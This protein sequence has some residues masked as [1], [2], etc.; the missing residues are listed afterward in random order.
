MIFI[1]RAS[2]ETVTI[3]TYNVEHFNDHFEGRRLTTRKVAKESDEAKEMVAAIKKANDEDNWEVA[4]TILDPKVD[5]DIIM[6]QEC[7][8]PEDL[9]Y[10]NK[11]WLKGAYETVMILPTNTGDR[12]QN[13]AMMVKPGFKIIQKKDQYYKEL[14]PVKKHIVT[15]RKGEPDR[16]EDRPTLFARGPSFF[17][18]ESPGGYHFWVGTNHMKSKFGNG[19]EVTAWRNREAVRIHAIMVELTKAGPGDLIFLGDM[20]DESGLDEFEKENGGDT[21]G[22]ILGPPDDGF[23]LATRPLLARGE[24]SFGGYT[25]S[26][27]RSFI[28]HAFAS[29]DMAKKIKSVSVYTDHLAPVASD[30]Y[31]VTL[32][33][34]LPTGTPT[35]PAP[36]TVPAELQDAM[37]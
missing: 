19:P 29:A 9:D 32:K 30:H 28:D 2:A 37:P 13:V 10:F 7:C 1:A 20:N 14:D 11:R 6:I 16:V 5:P 27:H 12:V 35:K 23:V 18:M 33:I 34:E 24:I 15:S 25:R 22:N 36:K 4:E 26:D 3:T 31:P 17:E 21:I 8:S